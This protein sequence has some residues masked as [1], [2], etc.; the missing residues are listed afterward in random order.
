[1][2][3]LNFCRTVQLGGLPARNLLHSSVTNLLQTG[4]ALKDSVPR[5]V[6]AMHY[7][8]L[9]FNYLLSLTII[10]PHSSHQDSSNQKTLC[11]H[12]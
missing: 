9:K 12:S 7:F 4:I 5:L 1:M 2:C 11:Q 3:S 8:D 10:I 6:L